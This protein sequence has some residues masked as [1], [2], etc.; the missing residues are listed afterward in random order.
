MPREM[1]AELARL[2]R[3]I[4][5][6]I[7]RLRASYEL[8]LDEFRGLYISDEQVD[9]LLRIRH[10]QD[11][12]TAEPPPVP[13][14]ESRWAELLRRFGL[15]PL[16]SDLLL[17]GAAPELDRKYEALFAYLNNNVAQRWPT[18]DLA[19]RLSS[20]PTGARAVLAPGG[21]LT[22]SGLVS[23][24]PEQ[25]RQPEPA[26]EYAS[27]P[28]VARF[29]LGLDP[30]LPQGLHLHPQQAGDPGPLLP[31]HA[32]LGRNDAPIVVLTAAPGSLRL[33]SAIAL[34]S[35]H[36]TRVLEA[37]L[38]ATSPET[39][40][41]EAALIARLYGALVF[42]R[43]VEDLLNHETPASQPLGAAIAALPGPVLVAASS[44]AP[45]LTRLLSREVIRIAWPEPDSAA[46]RALW[47]SSLTPQSVAEPFLLDEIA[48]RFRLTPVQ[49]RNAARTAMAA[50]AL[51]NANGH[52]LAAE[53]LFH[54]ARE[55][56][57][58]A[59][60][61]LATRIERRAA[62]RDLVLPEP[63]LAR[64]RQ[65]AAAIGNRGLVQQQWGMG[66]L[67]ASPEGLSVLFHGASGTGKTMA[68]SV[69]SG[70]LGLDLYRIEL[71]GVVSK[72]I[73]ETE[74]NL[75]RIFR[76]A[77]RSNAVLL[78]DEADALFGRRSEVKDA[79]DRYA[80]LEIAYLLQR[81]EEHDGPV[82]LATN[83]AKNMDQAF[84]RRLHYVVEFPRPD[85]FAREALWRQMLAPPLPC[86]ADVDHADLAEQFELT[87][88]EIRKAALEAAFMAAA[89]SRV[90]TMAQ[91]VAVSGRE[92]QRQGKMAPGHG[93]VAWPGRLRT[94]A[95]R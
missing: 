88:G 32:L 64:L 45:G 68:A 44:P 70:E 31:L 85:A 75:D 48:E 37:D 54:A 63:T 76:A 51:E 65:V 28:A 35:R 22:Q 49:I 4:Q 29:L 8:S 57:R 18:I 25:T 11:T 1:T 9:A 26:R 87:G 94:D 50:H 58:D 2:D 77:R 33:E 56:T 42:L 79:H 66:R 41:H 73:G 43:G 60:G 47:A 39:L 91:L 71:A 69:I 17:I 80:N 12:A 10:G 81:M 40:L 95:P 13:A 21:G 30:V 24:L 82:I 55:Q 84:T 92:L 72:Y 23:L 20:E 53:I 62:W 3:L 15:G 46:R 74:K 90:V 36:S 19:G 34:A 7:L 86:A 5:R 78:F 61:S 6:E 27:A 59:L 14:P 38:A 52:P 16:E 89:D 83:L 93:V 67:S